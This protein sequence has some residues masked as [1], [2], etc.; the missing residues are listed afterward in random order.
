MTRKT[1][2]YKAIEQ[3]K[4]NEGNEEIIQ[5][6]KDLAMANPGPAIIIL[7]NDMRQTWQL[8][9]PY[10]ISYSQR[11]QSEVKGIFGNERVVFK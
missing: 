10:T 1:A 9:S 5:K 2:L 8:N 3:L 6:L 11:V 7:V 4:T